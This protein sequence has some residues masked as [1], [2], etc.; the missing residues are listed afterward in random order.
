MI[1]YD[2]SREALNDVC[3]I[4]E[5]VARDSITAA[6]EVERRLFETFESLCRFPGQGHRRRNL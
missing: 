1:G 5:Y 3:E 4:W 2:L 6:D